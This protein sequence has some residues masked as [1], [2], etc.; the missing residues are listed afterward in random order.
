M[1]VGDKMFTA[2]QIKQ[3]I[4]KN[5]LFRFYTSRAWRAIAD[6]VRKDQHNECQLCK[7]NG[8]YS[9]ADVVYHVNYIRN[10]PDLAY[11]KTYKDINGNEKP[12]L[13]CLC[14]RCHETIHDRN[15]IK[16]FHKGF[17]TPEKW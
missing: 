8:R 14:H 4:S 12:Q 15:A 2:D 6:Q 16:K 11:S 7:A 13:I 10:R 5:K 3:L 1:K 17:F 9:K